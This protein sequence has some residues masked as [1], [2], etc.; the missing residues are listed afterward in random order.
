MF[1]MSRAAMIFSGI[2]ALALLFCFDMVAWHVLPVGFEGTLAYGSLALLGGFTFSLLSVGCAIFV[3][4]KHGAT[5]PNL[6]LC[7]VTVLFIIAFC[8]VALYG[9]RHI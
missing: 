7:S 5:R 2:A 8:G 4:V 9:T 1:I 6:L 3:V